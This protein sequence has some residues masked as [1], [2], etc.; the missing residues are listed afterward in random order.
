MIP[1]AGNDP[2]AIT[3]LEKYEEARASEQAQG[4]WKVA[5]DNEIC[6]LQRDHEVGSTDHLRYKG[7]F[8]QPEGYSDANFGADPIWE[9]TEVFK[10][11]HTFA[12]GR[13][14]VVIVEWWFL[15]VHD[16][17]ALSRAS[18]LQKTIAPSTTVE[19]ADLTELA[20]ICINSIR[21]KCEAA[22]YTRPI[23]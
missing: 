1:P 20:Y 9:K 17:R 23:C 21:G 11:I 6:G 3:A 16:R 22:V 10:R 4:C 2:A 8:F 19:E 5:M 13:E 7:G 12:V 14:V 15:V 18:T